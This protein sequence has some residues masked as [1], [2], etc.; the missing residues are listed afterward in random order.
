MSKPYMEYQRAMKRRASEASEASEARDKVESV[1][2]YEQC[3]G[4][5][6]YGVLVQ[7]GKVL[8]QKAHDPCSRYS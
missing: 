4:C 3:A 2:R 7:V 1:E 8:V 5:G 6:K